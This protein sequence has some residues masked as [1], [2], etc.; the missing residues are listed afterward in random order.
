MKAIQGPSYEP[1]SRLQ[2]R[3]DV[4]SYVK[5]NDFKLKSSYLTSSVRERDGP[6]EARDYRLEQINALLKNLL[7]FSDL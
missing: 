4:C 6:S 1:N 5:F 3:S 7:P 2:S